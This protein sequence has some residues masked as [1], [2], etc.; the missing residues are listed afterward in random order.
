MKRF[1][2]LLMS[3]MI[4]F[5]F[6]G[7]G[8]NVENAEKDMVNTDSIEGQEEP[9]SDSQNSGDP[10]PD[11]EAESTA[12]PTVD[13][14]LTAMSSTFI[15]SEVY[16]MMMEPLAYVG[17]TVKMEGNCGIYV[18]E[19]TGKKYYA[20]IVQDATQCC[21]QGLEFVLDENQYSEAD[22]PNEGDEVTITG[23]F[24]TYEEN[25]GTYLTMKNAV[26][27]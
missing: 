7:C 4:A 17:K 15:Y 1:L 10:Q 9:M 23:E 2:V 13:I 24:S 12:D 14:D 18:D 26:M 8:D 5:S 19:Q 16:N 25:G 20:C 3:S 6:A 22:Y 27:Q 11:S 21:S